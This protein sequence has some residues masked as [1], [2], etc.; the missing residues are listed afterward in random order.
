MVYVL[1]Y[2]PNGTTL[3]TLNNI[4][5]GMGAAPVY[6]DLSLPSNRRKEYPFKADDLVLYG[7]ITAGMLFTGNKEIFEHLHGN[8]AAFVGVAMYGNGYYGVSLKQLNKRAA[9]AG[10]HVIALAAFI[11]QHAQNGTTASGRPDNKDE[12]IQVDFGRRITEKKDS[13]DKVIPVG[14]SRSG[15]YNTIIFV[16]QFMQGMDYALPCFMK[17]KEA[18]DCCV[19]CGKCERNCL[20]SAITMSTQK[21]PSFDAKK[22]IACYRCVN[23]CPKQAIH[24]TSGLM[25]GIVK[26]FGGKFEERSEPTIII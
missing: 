23:G 15:L 5:A 26:N 11:G 14:W 2:S 6:I 3:R 12:K 25:N 19:G 1:Y 7:T 4:V 20:V 8:G 17:K 16:R 10:F 9:S 24:C 13:L 18:T 21:R 22:C